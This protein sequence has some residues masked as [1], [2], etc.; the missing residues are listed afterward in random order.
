LQETVE[1]LEK[2]NSDLPYIN[3]YYNKLTLIEISTQKII[4]KNE[5]EKQ[6]KSNI[7]EN[8]YSEIIEK[9]EKEVK[10]NFSFSW[11][12]STYDYIIFIVA[13][14]GVIYGIVTVIRESTQ[15]E[16]TDIVAIIFGVPIAAVF[17]GA[18]GGGIGW[19]IKLVVNESAKTG[20]YQS[21]LDDNLNKVNLS[22]QEQNAFNESKKGIDKFF[23]DKESYETF[24]ETVR[25]LS[26]DEQQIEKEIKQLN[27]SN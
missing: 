16:D 15:G 2:I 27:L 9:K 6:G 8:K 23:E 24:Q 21:K 10:A 17:F 22:S 4:Q 1:Q 7:L 25:I 26:L 12:N 13:A 11:D 18:I 5:L 20:A 3:H 14:I 19:L